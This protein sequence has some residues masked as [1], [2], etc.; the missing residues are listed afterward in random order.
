MRGMKQINGFKW[1]KHGHAT[2]P[3][4]NVLM[5]TRITAEKQA[6]EQKKVKSG[7]LPL[8]KNGV[9]WLIVTAIVSSDLGLAGFLGKG[10]G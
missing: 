8:F 4:T 2:D 5:M 1:M 9:S 10:G 6:E 7:A 3:F